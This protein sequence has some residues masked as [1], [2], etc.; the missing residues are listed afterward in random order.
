LFG[1]EVKFQNIAVWGGA[2]LRIRSLRDRKQFHD[3]DGQAAAAGISDTAW[4]LFGQVWASG[5]VL[6]DTVQAYDLSGKRI[7]EVGCGLAIPSLVACRRGADITAL[8]QHPL[9]AEFLHEN[10]V[11]NALPGLRFR[12]ANWSNDDAA[13]GKFDLIIASDV[14]Y[15]RHQPASLANFINRHASES[16]KVLVIDPNRA[17][18]ARFGHFMRGLG[19]EHKDTPIA[20]SWSNG[21]AYKGRML[22]SSR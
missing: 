12:C 1:Y 15:E 9:A 20:C 3:P 5:L 16:A 22:V 7:L 8:D 14:L 2:P 13:L 11:L 6:A 19:Y 4:P 18:H 21:D 17:Y 10:L